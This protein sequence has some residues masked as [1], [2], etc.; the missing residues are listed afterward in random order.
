MLLSPYHIRGSLVLVWHKTA[1]EIHTTP[2]L[3][4][5]LVR[6]RDNRHMKLVC[7]VVAAQKSTAAMGAK[8]KGETLEHEGW[9]GKLPLKRWHFRMDVKVITASWVSIW[10]EWEGTGTAFQE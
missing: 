3:I 9:S 6:H 10:Q 4:Y 5:T 2:A 7:P 8:H 1:R